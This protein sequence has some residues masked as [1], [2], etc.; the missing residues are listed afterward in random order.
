MSANP[1]DRADRFRH[2]RRSDLQR[3]QLREPPG[4]SSSIRSPAPSPIWWWARIKPSPWDASSRWISS[5]PQPTPRSNSRISGVEFE[6]LEKAQETDFVPGA[7]GKWGYGQ[8]QM[9]SHPYFGLGL[10]HDDDGRHR[11]RPSEHG[12]GYDGPDR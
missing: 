6:A 4:V 12:I 3:S 9:L 10:R 1:H 11:S 2:R 8:E 5:S 7:R